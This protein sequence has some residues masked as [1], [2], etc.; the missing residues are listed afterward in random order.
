MIYEL[1]I[2]GFNEDDFKK[3]Y[4]RHLDDLLE[5]AP[6]DASASS[7][8]SKIKKGYEGIIDICS[9]QGHFVA[10]AI[11]KEPQEV[12]LALFGQIQSQLRDWQNN[13]LVGA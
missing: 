10:K 4:E 3:N 1:V 8:I 5:S 9:S 2:D 11:C 13:R 6:S 7:K 12:V